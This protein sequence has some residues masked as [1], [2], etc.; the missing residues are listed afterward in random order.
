MIFDSFCV[1]GRSF[2]VW[3]IK[4]LISFEPI[5][6]AISYKIEIY[7]DDL[8]VKTIDTSSTN[9]EYMFSDYGNYKARYKGFDTSGTVESDWSDWSKV[10][11]VSVDFIIIK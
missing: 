8:L 2:W 11:Y 10:N 7:K 1:N 9:I 6:D 5:I 3:G 4:V